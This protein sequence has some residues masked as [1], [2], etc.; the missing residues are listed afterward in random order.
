MP[1]HRHNMVASQVSLER[2]ITKSYRLGLQISIGYREEQTPVLLRK[3]VI[4]I[5]KH[6]HPALFQCNCSCR[7]R[8]GTRSLATPSWMQMHLISPGHINTHLALQTNI[9]KP[10]L[11]KYLQ[12]LQI[13]TQL[14]H[15]K[16]SMQ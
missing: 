16:D 9:R 11:H 4:F 6:F 15:F 14:Q 13:P 5:C 1:L 8:F 7:L 3:L 10:D 2:F 12:V